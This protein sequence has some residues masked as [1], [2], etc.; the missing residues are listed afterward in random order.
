MRIVKLKKRKRTDA[1]LWNIKDTV[2]LSRYGW[3]R[4]TI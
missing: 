3:I 1:K 2:A 4:A